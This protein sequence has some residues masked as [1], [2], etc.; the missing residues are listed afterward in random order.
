MC[1]EILSFFL[2]IKIKLTFEKLSLNS[3]KGRF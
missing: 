2:K 1:K 3:K